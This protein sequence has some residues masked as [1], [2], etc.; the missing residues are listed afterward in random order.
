MFLIAYLLDPSEMIHIFCCICNELTPAAVYYHDGALRLAL[1]PRPQFSKKT[2]SALVIQIIESAR[3][4]LQ[5]EQQRVRQGGVD[6]GDK[7]V[8]ELT[9]ESSFGF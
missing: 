3:R 1:P 8:K 2:A 4:M 7:L 6:D 5:F 9:G